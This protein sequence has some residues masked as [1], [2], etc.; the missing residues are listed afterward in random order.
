MTPEQIDQ[1]LTDTLAD[2]QLTRTERRAIKDV[3][4]DLGGDA[5]IHAL[6]RQRAFEV[7][8]G[9]LLGR[10]TLAVVEWL[11]D[12]VKALVPEAPQKVGG[13]AEAWFSP[14]DDCPERIVALLRTALRSVDICVFTI[15]D[16]R[17]ADAVLAAHRRGVAVRLLTDDEKS[18][19][20]G[21]DVDKLA[22]R[23]VAVRYDRTQHH[24]H[25]KFAVID[26]ALLLT[27]SYNWTRSA[28]D[29]NDENFL[30]TDEPRLVAAYV[31][32]FDV[33][34]ERHG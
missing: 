18:L 15:T 1:V 29:F 31:G 16:D 26:G 3:V 23:G 13:R 30:V 34:W 12:V 28:A 24:M 33:L 14:D 9:A 5:R 19:D 25:H 7:A 10:D 6:F 20:V 21:S 32:Q 17:L 27:G 2:R 8:K 22:S 11:E 4:Q